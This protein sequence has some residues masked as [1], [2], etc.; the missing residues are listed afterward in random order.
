M[1]PGPAGIAS[2]QESF[3][4]YGNAAHS[5]I[6]SLRPGE[7]RKI[8]SCP[9]ATKYRTVTARIKRDNGSMS[10]SFLTL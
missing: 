9:I 10:D 5:A 1:L 6:V 3:I 2:G 4:S 7:I 8:E